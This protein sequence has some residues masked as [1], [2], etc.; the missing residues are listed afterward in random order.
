MLSIFLFIVKKSLT[1]ISLVLFF[2]LAAGEYLSVL[3]LSKVYA[4]PR[5]ITSV[6]IWNF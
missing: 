1:T 2:G 4:P 6:V 3:S 5:Y